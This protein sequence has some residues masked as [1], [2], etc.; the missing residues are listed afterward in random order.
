[1]TDLDEH[2]KLDKIRR[3]FIANVS[4]ELRTP[5]TV[6]TG[7]LEILLEQ[8]IEDAAALK[9][10]LAQMQQQ[11]HRMQFLVEDL[12]LLSQLESVLP[13]KSAMVEVNVTKL[14][15]GIVEDARS[16]SGSKA[17]VIA[18]QA[19]EQLKIKGYPKELRSAFS[20]IIVNAVRYTPAHGS[21]CITWKKENDQA[22]LSVK[23][24]GIGIEAEHIPR[25]TERFYRVDKGRSRAIGGTGLG[26][27]IVKHVLLRHDSHLD[28]QSMPGLGSEFKCYFNV[29]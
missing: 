9:K 10:I 17:H 22:C 20:N 8:P 15:Q 6:L 24:T 14:L 12:L 21:V 1:M 7:Y 4:H 5:L 28:V 23:D 18:L 26:L 13:E 16:L 27:A 11:T 3:D 25:L 29:D 19:D 2:H